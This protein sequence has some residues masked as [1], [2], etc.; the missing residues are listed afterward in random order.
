MRSWPGLPR[1]D[2]DSTLDT[3]MA[4][5]LGLLPPRESTRF[6]VLPA[7]PHAWPHFAGTV[8]KGLDRWE[9]GYLWPRPGRWP[10]AA[11]SRSYNEQVRDVVL[12]GAGIPDGWAGVVRFARDERSA[13]FAVMFAYLAFGWCLGDDLYFVPDHGHQVVQTDHHD[14]IHVECAR[15]GP[16]AGVRRPHGERGLPVAHGTAGRGVQVAALDAPTARESGTPADR[17]RE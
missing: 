17:P 4:T 10:L 16:G 11:N 14:V 9:T 3:P 5:C 6:W 1:S 7:D 12:R 8:L 15:R 13:V 2:S